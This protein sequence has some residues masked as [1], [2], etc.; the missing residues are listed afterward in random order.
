MEVPAK[1]KFF[2]M[3]YKWDLIDRIQ[4]RLAPNGPWVISPDDHKIRVPEGRMSVEWKDNPWLHIKQSGERACKI[5]SDIFV[6]CLNVLPKK[7]INCWK[8]VFRPQYVRDM[9]N[10]RNLMENLSAKHGFDCKLG[11]EIRP[12]TTGVYGKWGLWGCYFYNNSQKAGI[13]CWETVKDAIAGDED[14]K[15]LLNDVDKDGY[16]ARLVLKRGCT[17]F[18]ISQFGDSKDWKQSADDEEW[19]RIVWD[20]FEVQ[21]LSG[22]Q[23]EMVK[24]H[25]VAGWFKKAHTAGDPTVKEFNEGTMLWRSTRFYHKELFESV[26]KK[27]A[28]AKAVKKGGKK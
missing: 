25:V 22:P 14:L 15:H 26:K 3:L 2:P 8:V 9:L 24:H 1:E 27:R 12:W 16:P 5:Y 19:E 20:K 21:N 13:N 23:C 10:M 4:S 6:Q 28:V 18:E 17:E 7:C 11:A